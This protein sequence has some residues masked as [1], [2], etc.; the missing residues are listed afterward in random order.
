MED[1]ELEDLI[2]YCKINNRIIPT[3]WTELWEMLPNIKRVGCSWDPLPPLILGAW[4]HS[5]ELEKQ[6]RFFS[7]L[8]YAYKHGILNKVSNYLRNLSEN[9]W[10]HSGEA[11]GISLEDYYYS[12]EV[13]EAKVKPSNDII[14]NSLKTLHN[15]WI[16]IAGEKIAKVTEP[17]N[18]SGKKARRLNV[19]VLDEKIKPDWGSWWS[20]DISENPNLFTNF[21]EK[22]NKAINPHSI[23]H[24][25]FFKR[26][27]RSK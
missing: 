25:F 23:D 18:F 16:E 21:R 10:C 4:W 15:N 20:L 17:Y 19:K 8:Q 22:I 24:I 6:E 9:E 3:K 26:G 11:G 5:S 27:K 13:F 7:H 1:N 2:Q 14:I 12:N